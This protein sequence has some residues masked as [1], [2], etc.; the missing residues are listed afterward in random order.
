[1]AA[2]LAAMQANAAELDAERSARLAKIEAEEA[3][4]HERDEKARAARG[5]EV[6]PSFLRE[7]EKKI[8]EKGLGDRLA[9]R[10]RA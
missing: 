1:M 4:K 8:G 7:E 6:R 5:I 9:G 3:A 10:V 2:R